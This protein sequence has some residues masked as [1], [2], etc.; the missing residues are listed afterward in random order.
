MVISGYIALGLVTLV[1]LGRHP[2]V[3]SS[4]DVHC[5]CK[6]ECIHIIGNALEI[7]GTHLQIQAT[8]DALFLATQD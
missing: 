2:S 8:A 5:A 6:I 4:P 3:H 1:H 7:L